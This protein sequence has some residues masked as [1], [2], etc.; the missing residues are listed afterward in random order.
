MKK[1][2]MYEQICRDITDGIVSGEYGKRDLLPSEKEL[3]EQYG[4]SRVTAAKAMKL[5]A[6]QGIIERVR[7]KGSFVSP[8]AG[9]RLNES[10]AVDSSSQAPAEYGERR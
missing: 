8:H 10:A 1:T 9:D 5:L 2:I 4:V 7:G 3:A 6:D